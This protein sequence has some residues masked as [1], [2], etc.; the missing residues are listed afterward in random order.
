MLC[1]MMRCYDA[2]NDANAEDTRPCWNTQSLRPL[3]NDQ[4]LFAVYFLAVFSRWLFALRLIF[5]RYFRA[6]PFISAV[7]SRWL[8][9][10]RLLFRRH[11]ALHSLRNDFG[12]KNL[13]C[14]PL[15]T[16]F[17]ASTKLL[18]HPIRNNFLK[19]RQFSSFVILWWKHIS[20]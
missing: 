16:T 13:L 2:K 17:E 12:A 4:D 7:F 20:F 9:A 14:A 15:G 18:L 3:R 5:R 8:F 19:L 1:D 11:L 10:L 6:S